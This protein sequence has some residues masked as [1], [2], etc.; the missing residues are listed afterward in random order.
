M[1][2]KFS[3]QFDQKTRSNSGKKNIIF[4]VLKIKKSKLIIIIIIFIISTKK[5]RKKIIFFSIYIWY[6]GL[7]GLFWSV[8]QHYLRMEKFNK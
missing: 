6:S 2:N 5:Y 1:L 7:S 4:L 3:D 8:N